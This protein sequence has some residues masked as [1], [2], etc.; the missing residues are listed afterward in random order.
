MKICLAGT[1]A[2][3]KENQDKV[4]ESK[5]ILE[6]FY[7]IKEWQIPIIKKCNLFL[8]DSGAFSFMGN[9]RKG[10]KVNDEYFNDY[11]EKYINF[12]NKYDIKYFFELDIDV[13][14]GYEKTLKLRKRLEEGTG[15][16]CIPVFHKN[17]G[18]KEW[19][20]MCREY[21]YVA[22]GTS[23]K[24][25]SKWTRKHPEVIAKML[26]I[27]KDN[28]CKVHGLGFTSL[29]GIKKLHFYS[30]DSTSWKS[31]N[32]FGS[33]YVFKNN[34]LEKIKKPINKRLKSG[35]Y[36]SKV[37]YWNFKEWVKF[38]KYAEKYY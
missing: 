13:V 18:I 17:R 23:G 34:T 15:K 21:D 19:E 25:D 32:M 27:A 6:S 8:L 10:V 30:V 2:I 29:K 38:Q 3:T 16:K 4:K 35:D 14:I 7:S 9:A 26:Q 37:E 36:Y 11:L 22:I 28:N 31:G 24:N 12:I 33:L 20:K 1:C 5:F